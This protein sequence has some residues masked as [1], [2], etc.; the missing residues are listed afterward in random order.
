MRRQMRHWISC[1]FT[2][3]PAIIKHRTLYRCTHASASS[4]AIT[5][6]L[7]SWTASFTRLLLQKTQRTSSILAQAPVSS[8]DVGGVRSSSNAEQSSPIPGLKLSF[9]ATPKR[10]LLLHR[11]QRQNRYAH[12]CY[13]L[14]A[15]FSSG[16][17]MLI[18]V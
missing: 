8:L 15:I 11:H 17:M 3:I 1:E 9:S 4:L 7:F 10:L 12:S 18:R 13:N 6:S 16:C 5:R 14:P 2:I